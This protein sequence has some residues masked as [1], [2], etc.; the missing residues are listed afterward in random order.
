MN[1]FYEAIDAAGESVLGK[2]D[3]IDEF[4]VQSK[5][6]AQGLQVQSLAIN[7]SVLVAEPI[8]RAL[9]DEEPAA[10]GE[11]TLA[12]A[13]PAYAGTADTS[14][15]L[16]PRRTSMPV[17]RAR[18]VPAPPAAYAAPPVAAPPVALPSVRIATEPVRSA[19]LPVAQR[20]GGITLS[21][22]AARVVPA[23]ARPGAAPSAAAPQTYAMA[24]VSTRNLMFFFQ[25]LAAL[26]KSGVSVYNALDTVSTRTGSAGLKRVA[27][28]MAERARTGGA[29][30]GVMAQYPG[31]FPEHVVGLTRAGELGGFLEIALSEIAQG[32]ERNIAL[33]RSAWIPK[34]MALQAFIG[35]PLV[36]PLFPTVFP[37]AD[38]GLYLKLVLLRNM[39]IAAALL[40]AVYFGSR[41]LQRPEHRRLRD[42]WSLKLPPFGDLQRQAAIATFL[43]TLKRLYQAGVSPSYAWEGAMNTAGNLAIRDQLTASANL[44]A[45]GASLPDAFQATGLFNN[46]IE[47]LVMT[48]HESGQVV[49]MLDQAERYYQEQ[50]QEKTA[51]A[52]FAMLRL[53]VL[54]ML[55]FGG[56]TVCWMMYSY[57][58]G[59]F[60]FAD[61]FAD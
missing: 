8:R 59:I 38:F 4:D 22:D 9:E 58:H 30:S 37:N 54:A 49:E 36:Q 27:R 50:V 40:G 52:K 24:G 31:I 2:I 19:P 16:D 56:A 7:N 25:Q 28:E 26:V 32:Y 48:G 60:A 13:A 61:S 17:S 3:G 29:I 21:G 14:P 47:H 11:R 34:A 1:Y 33:Y 44:I 51:K 45:R 46:Q 18:P 12:L 15:V 39:P 42:R 5:L 53:G 43:G 55:V 6:A 20:S 23:P 57:F 41:M 35:L 10:A